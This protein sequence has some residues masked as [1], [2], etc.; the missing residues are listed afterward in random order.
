MILQN[1][2]ILITGATGLIGGGIVDLL[3]KEHPKTEVYIIVRDIQKAKKRFYK[4]ANNPHLHMIDGDVN[5]PLNTNIRFHY[6]IHTASNANPNAY[7]TDPVNTMWT[8]LNGTHNLFEYGRTHGIERFLFVSSGEIYGEGEKS[9][10]TEN[11]SG[12]INTMQSRSCYPSSKRAAETLCV[13]YSE[14]YNIDIVVARPCHTYGPLFS[15]HDNRAFAQFIRKA[16]A[17]ENI[18]LKSSGEQYRSWIYIDD[19]ASAILSILQ[20]GKNKEAYNIADEQSNVTIK[21]FAQTI[22]K[23]ANVEIQFDIPDKTE[24]AGYSPI[25]RSVFNTSKLRDLG[26][27]PKFSLSEGIKH[28][29]TQTN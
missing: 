28:S 15:E 3:L 13:C 26:W 8:N 10:W 16:R 24:K 18:I 6:I 1:K 12:Y 7:S 29:I 27:K 5:N 23:M 2:N 21:T 11:D 14:Q 25:K 19:C 4:Y 22:A 20:F 9:E 17:K